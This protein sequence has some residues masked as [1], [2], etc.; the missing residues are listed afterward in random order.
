M[1]GVQIDPNDEIIKL[2]HLRKS[3]WTTEGEQQVLQDVSLSIR[4]GETMVIIGGSGGGKSVILKHM[5]G[6]LQPDGGEVVVDG[7]VISTPDYFDAATI[8]RK[9]GMLFQM[10]ALFDSMSVGENIAFA[11][12]EHNPGIPEESVDEIIARLLGLINLNPA[13]ASKMPSELSGG[14]KKR[15]SLARTLAVEPEIVLYDEPTTGLDP[16][17][18]DVINDLI[19]DTQ[20]QFNV[21]SVVVTHD[22]VSAFKVADRI[23]MLYQGHIIFVGTPEDVRTTHNPY[24]QQFVRGQRKL[25]AVAN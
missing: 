6:L 24:V 10:G 2:N 13:F 21:T 8:R 16:I 19:I 11:L 22:M 17:T 25:E 15:V 14:M 1:P 12:R 4:R 7:K 23:A 5:I 9:M 18:S 20:H 3:F